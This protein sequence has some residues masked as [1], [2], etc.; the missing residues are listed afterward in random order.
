MQP[1]FLYW[2]VVITLTGGYD[3]WDEKNLL[4][5]LPEWVFIKDRVEREIGASKTTNTCYMPTDVSSSL[6]RA[7]SAE[8]AFHQFYIGGV[9]LVSKLDQ[10]SAQDSLSPVPFGD[11]S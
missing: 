6:S 10:N 7:L 5:R 8:D 9:G 3:L 11:Q 2:L 4:Y 1:I